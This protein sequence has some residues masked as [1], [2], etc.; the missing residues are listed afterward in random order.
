MLATQIVFVN[1]LIMLMSFYFPCKFLW[2]FTVE[3]CIIW[4]RRLSVVV[5]DFFFIN[6][7]EVRLRLDNLRVI[8]QIPNLIFFFNL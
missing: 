5:L 1:I 3:S 6:F 7:Q 8:S 4:G 2:G